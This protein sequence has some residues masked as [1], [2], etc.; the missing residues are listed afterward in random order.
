MYLSPL[1]FILSK[2][3]AE[4]AKKKRLHKTFLNP[5]PEAELCRARLRL[6]CAARHLPV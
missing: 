2:L 4:T 6:R 3:I 1:L 5:E